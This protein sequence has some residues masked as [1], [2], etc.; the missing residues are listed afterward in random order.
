MKNF[1]HN[2]IAINLGMLFATGLAISGMTQP[3]KIINFLDVT[4]DWHP[5]LLLVM[6]GAIGVYMPAYHF[7]VKK[8]EKPLLEDKFFVPPQGKIDKKLI[9]GSGIFGIGWGVSGF[10]PGPALVSLLAHTQAWAY[11][12]SLVIGML[13]AKLIIKYKNNCC[14]PIKAN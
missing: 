11:I 1:I 4:G 3:Q 6:I 13:L 10:C 9:F 14:K 2:I 7:L 8:K 12:L 5:A